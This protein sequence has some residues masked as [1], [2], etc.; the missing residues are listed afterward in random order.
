MTEK[1]LKTRIILRNDTAEAWGVANPILKAGE[2]GIEKDTLKFKIGDGVKKWNELSYAGT[3]VKVEGTGDVITGAS[4]G[5][6][7][8]LTLTKGNLN[9]ENV[10]LADDLTATANIGVWTV[11]A[12]GSG[13]I[14]NKGDNLGTFLK[15]ILAKEVNP[16]TTQP[17]YSLTLSNAGAKEVGTKITPAFTGSWNAGKYTYGPATGCT[18]SYKVTSTTVTTPV[19]TLSGSFAEITVA[20]DTNY[21]V[22]G[23]CT[24]TA[25][26]VPVTNIGNKYPA[27]QIGANTTGITKTTS[28]I[29]G[30]RAWF[31]G[32][33]SAG[34]QNPEAMTSALVRSLGTSQNGSFPASV[35]TNKMQQMYFAAPKGKVKSIS[36]ANAVNGA[37]QTVTKASASVNVQGAN[38]YTA[39]AYDI[40]YVNNAVAESGSS[41]FKVTVTK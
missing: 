32:Y 31:Y 3:Q 24:Y 36:V 11:P 26:A 9:L 12:S 2:I 19:T 8:T 29:T 4:I 39:V 10:Y 1:L 38:G 34:T 35:T 41:T 5:A 33:K 7:G 23:V 16:A 28:A 25:G 18:P 14:G 27:G 21:K 15:S 40:F 6:D 30:Y 17:T 22:T 37:P 13:K 20:D